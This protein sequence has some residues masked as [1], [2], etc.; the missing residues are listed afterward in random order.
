MT[1]QTAPAQGTD[2]TYP[3]LH[4]IGERINPGFVSTKALFDNEDI[5]GIQELAQKQVAK[6]AEYLNINVGERALN[7]PAFM[8][9]VVQA[10]QAVVAV[11]LSLDFPNVEVQEHCL[12]AYDEAKAGGQMPI[13][14]S[15]SE[16]RWEMLDLLKIK[17]FKLFMMTSERNEGGE[18][19]ANKT[20]EEVHATTRRMVDKVLS[21]EYPFVMD[22]LFID[23]S[24]GPV[25]ADT[26]GLTKMAIDAI[27]LIG[28]DPDLQGL[29]MSVGLSNISI[30]LPPKGLDGRPIKARVE[31]AFLNRTVPYGMDYII[32]TPG[33]KYEQLPD[34]E[35]VQA[36]FDEAIA[37][38]GFETVMCIQ[39]LYM[40][41][42]DD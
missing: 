27:R 40:D 19:V 14:N 3:G 22:D 36:K 31:S 8:V 12:K 41:E 32:G 29:H 28:E 37:A 42:D 20:A 16:L 21:K 35:F 7:D 13:V 11:P 2:V 30:M 34:D 39:E 26:E 9:E 5:T 1:V 18:K 15:I 33:R 17:P 24:I 10:V 6:G 38:G 4:I 23:V 25:G